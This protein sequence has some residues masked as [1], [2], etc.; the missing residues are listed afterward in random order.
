MEAGL[1]GEAEE[2]DL[3]GGGE[4]AAGKGVG[5]CELE[6][7]LGGAPEQGRGDGTH[8]DGKELVGAGEAVAGLQGSGARPGGGFEAQADAVAIAPGLGGVDGDFGG[9]DEAGALEE[10]GKDLALKVELSR[11]RGVLVVAA[12]AEAEVDAGGS[13]AVG[14]GFE[15][16]E[17]GGELDL[18][19]GQDV[20]ERA[21]VVGGERAAVEGL[22]DAGRDGCGFGS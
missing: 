21:G 15:D 1:I 22:E 19:A 9:Q 17:G 7:G 18:L 5:G 8:A 6:E 3:G 13:N 16:G 12:A 11:V 2:L 20:G 10:G 4:P 14:G